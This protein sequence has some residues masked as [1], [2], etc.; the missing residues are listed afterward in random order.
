MAIRPLSVASWG[1]LAGPPQIIEG[2]IE[3]TIDMDAALEVTLET[4]EITVALDEE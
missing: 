3:V 4:D 1:L 2:P